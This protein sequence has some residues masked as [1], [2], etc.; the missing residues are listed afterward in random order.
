MSTLIRP[1][2]L[3]RDQVFDHLAARIVA[4]ELQPLE[5]IRDHELQAQF[6][7]S[8]TPIRE[9]LIR[10]TEVGLIE[11]S[12][13]RYT[14]VAPVDFT[15]QADRAEAASALVAFCA[16]SAASS[17]TDAQVQHLDER[18]DALLRFH[19]NQSESR[20]GLML[21][22]ELWSAVADAGAN[23]I[24]SDVIDTRLRLHLTRVVYDIPLTRKRASRLSALLERLR[25]AVRE[26]DRDRVRGA[27]VALFKT[28][29][30][31]PLR[32]AADL[33]R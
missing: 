21:W 9:A 28:A 11:M 16:Y 20:E 31:Q 30:I 17:F 6:G 5:E 4:G 1:R 24:I 13:N 3:I 32:E 14:R 18:I 22:F 10:L 2:D 25:R 19:L 23:R 7:V 12:A 26:R 8:R 27:V 29:F 15:D 33:P